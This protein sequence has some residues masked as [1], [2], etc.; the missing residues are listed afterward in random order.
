MNSPVG[1]RRRWL[2]T[3][4]NKVMVNGQRNGSQ[5]PVQHQLYTRLWQLHHARAG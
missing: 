3:H 1:T 5:C 2:L 4:L